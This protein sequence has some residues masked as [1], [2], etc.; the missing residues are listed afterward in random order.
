MQYP[1]DY[2]RFQ[3]SKKTSVSQ[4][5]KSRLPKPHK[6]K[7]N[8]NNSEYQYYDFKNK[9]KIDDDWV[10]I[11]DQRNIVQGAF[12]FNTSKQRQQQSIFLPMR[13]RFPGFKQVKCRS[14][15]V[16]EQ[17]LYDRCEG[18]ELKMMFNQNFQR[19]GSVQDNQDLPIEDKN[20]TNEV[21][22]LQNLLGVKP[23]KKVEVKYRSSMGSHRKQVEEEQLSRALTSFEGSKLDIQI[24]NQ[25]LRKSHEMQ[26]QQWRG[27]FLDKHFK[28]EIEE[29]NMCQ[30]FDYG[31]LKQYLQ[32]SVN[33]MHENSF[34]V[35]PPGS[36][37]KK[38]RT[39]GFSSLSS[40]AKPSHPRA[41]TSHD[42]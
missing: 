4:V 11:G 40:H 21:K 41:I 14:S 25:R 1:C 10:P 8:M 22:Y 16:E 34:M 33:K 6:T 15:V 18:R 7:P 13:H 37:P 32:S 26:Q 17:M 35:A 23:M 20:Q 38:S 9:E 19:K 36:I 3:Y 28:K 42:I 12:V 29:M 5:P 24:E 27:Q 39:N 2:S 30:S 31:S